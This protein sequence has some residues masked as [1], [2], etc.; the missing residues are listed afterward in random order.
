MCSRIADA[1]CGSGVLKL[2]V[3]IRRGSFFRRCTWTP[4]GSFF[5]AP[6]G[7]FL[8]RVESLLHGD[9]EADGSGTEPDKS[10]GDE[11]SVCHTAY[12]FARSNLKRCVCGKL[13]LASCLF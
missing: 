4:D 2:W 7:I 9:D 11:Q 12:V 3:L 8:K 1:A 10:G 6:S 5:I 13:L